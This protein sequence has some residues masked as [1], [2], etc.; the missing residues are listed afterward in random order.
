MQITTEQ[1]MI[2][3]CERVNSS[4]TFSLELYDNLTRTAINEWNHTNKNL[5]S[6]GLIG[7]NSHLQQGINRVVF[8]YQGESRLIIEETPFLYP[9]PKLLEQEPS[10][11]GPM[12]G[13]LSNCYGLQSNTFLFH[14]QGKDIATPFGFQAAAAGMGRFREHPLVTATKELYEEAGIKDAECLFYNHPTDALPFM[15]TGK[16]PQILF[17]FGFAAD[18]S[19]FPK[20]DSLDQI[21]EF[22]ATTKQKIQSRELE[23]REGY[24]FTIP[25]SQVEQVTGELHDQGKFYGPIHE[26]TMNFVKA[27]KDSREIK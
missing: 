8:P 25:Y 2:E 23:Q 14:M 22:E 4:N 21:A 16:I 7:G 18:L 9:S 13:N 12:T 1:D 27:L 3:L 11:T 6:R 10:L 19:T 17:S 5:I 15:K 24:H 20:L 26:S